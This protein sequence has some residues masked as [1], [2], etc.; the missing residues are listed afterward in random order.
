MG[1]RR[2]AARSCEEADVELAFVA[3]DPNSNPG[4]SPTLYRTDRQ[5][6]VGKGLGGHRPRHAGHGYTGRRGVSGDPRPAGAVLP[7]TPVMR[8]ATS[9]DLAELCRGI[10]RSFMHLE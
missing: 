9:K 8:P 4:D 1:L 2:I 5:S 7:A 6:W 10:K 3:K